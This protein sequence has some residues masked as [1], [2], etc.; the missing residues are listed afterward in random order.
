MV[1]YD[2]DELKYQAEP[3][4]STGM[5]AP[6]VLIDATTWNAMIRDLWVLAK[7]REISGTWVKEEE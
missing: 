4:P 5:R 6:D 3:E 1:G 7:L 2:L